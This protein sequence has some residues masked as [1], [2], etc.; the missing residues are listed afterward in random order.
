MGIILSQKVDMLSEEDYDRV[1]DLVDE[2]LAGYCRQKKPNNVEQEKDEETV[3]ID[4]IEEEGG[5]VLRDL[6]KE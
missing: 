1:E 3:H 4:V 6:S 5:G 2:I